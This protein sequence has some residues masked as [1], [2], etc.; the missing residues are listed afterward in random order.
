M[1]RIMFASAAALAIGM[2]AC[3]SENESTFGEGQNGGTNPDGTPAI[4]NGLPEI[5]PTGTSS[6][7]VTEVAGAELAPTNLVFMYDKSGS[8]GAAPAFD[9]NQKWIPVGEGMK[10]F[11]ADPYSK[12]LRAS[13]QFFPDGDLPDPPGPAD[14]QRD[15]NEVCSFDYATPKVALTTASDASFVNAIESTAPAGG[16]PTVPAL[17]GAIAYAE[18]V[19]AER[20]GEKTVVVFVTDGEPG[21][22]IDGQFVPGCQ[23]VTNTVENAASIAA[24]AK[25]KNIPTYVIGVGP[26]LDKL[27]TVAEAGGTT[28]ALMVNISDPSTVAG[29]IR[30][31]LNDIRKREATCDFAVPPPPAGETLDPYAVNVV[32]AKGD[33]SQSVLAYSKECSDSSGWRYDDVKAPTR[34]MLCGSSCNDVKAEA[35]GKISI[36]F[37]CKTKIAVR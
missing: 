18:K 35:E 8:M 19:A 6:A 37:G 11:F 7:C 22:M 14:V 34:I 24:A 2:V 10:A 29:Q 20:P 21:F 36:A 25:A 4:S 16:T 13:L 3:G 12:T 31:G 9:P 23:N 33:G 17:Q 30:D 32:L 1:K 28:S 26:S 15:V 5:G 27:N